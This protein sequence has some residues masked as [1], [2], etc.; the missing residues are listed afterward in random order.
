MLILL[1]V[2][3][4]SKI[5]FREFESIV[6]IEVYE[7]DG[8]SKIKEIN[9]EWEIEEIIK[10]LHANPKEWRPVLHTLPSNQYTLYFYSV[11]TKMRTLLI[12]NTYMSDRMHIKNLSPEQYNDF[13][14]RFIFTAFDAIQSR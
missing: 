4:I 14:S 3:C 9:Q 2:G 10:Y 13:H 5:E 7:T 1:L 11:D 12:G 8:P 6:R